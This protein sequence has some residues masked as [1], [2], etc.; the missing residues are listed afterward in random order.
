MATIFTVAFG[1]FGFSLGIQRMWDNSLLWHIRTG[2]WI[3]DHGIPHHDP[4][5]FTHHGIHWIAQSWL[6]ELLYG[7]EYR[8]FLGAYGIRLMNGLIFVAIVVIA[9]RLALRLSGDV[10]RAVLVTAVSL[11]GLIAIGS[12]RPLIFGV[13][14]FLALVWVVEV[15]G[16]RIGRAAPVA[17][18]I[19]MWCWANV[20]GTFE[21]GF[22]YLVLHLVGRWLDG[23]K[24]SEGEE[25]RVALGAVIALAVVFVN[26]YGAELVLFPID[27]L[28]R[29]DTLAHIVEWQSPS[30]RTDQGKY[31]AIWMVVF[32]GA[33]AHTARRLGWRDSMLAVTFILLSFWAQRNIILTP[34]V[35][36]PIL[37]RSVSVDHKR[38][39]TRVRFGLVFVTLLALLFVRDGI[40]AAGEKNFLLDPYPVK[41]MQYLDTHGLLGRRILNDDGWGGYIILKYWPR[42]EVFFDDR[43]DMYPVAFSNEYFGLAD[44]AR[45]WQKTLRKYKIETIVWPPS[46]PLTQLLDSSSGWKRVH[47]DKTAVVFVR[48]DVL[49]RK[50]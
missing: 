36:L 14:A 17:I 22:A 27:L 10:V 3:L 50:G 32:I 31:L 23:S 9:F 7:I 34:L 38:E 46:Q 21:L 37:A 28:R 33:I 13:L 11:L 30:F 16:S 29:S 49:A 25:R 39:A 8:S 44:G 5:S 48:K 43:Y 20:H 1:V 15:P 19:I 45:G 24:P 42:Q 4:Y 35:L 47:Y 6:A 26:P 2:E 18:P 41:A 12:P 40:R